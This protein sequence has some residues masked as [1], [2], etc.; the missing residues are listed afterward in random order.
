[1]WAHV[2][3]EFRCRRWNWA[4]QKHNIALKN[5]HSIRELRRRY[6]STR[7]IYM[8]DQI[9]DPDFVNGITGYQSQVLSDV[10]DSCAWRR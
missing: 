1:M 5:C 8:V 7:A 4:M 6:L 2:H 3:T 10:S 9:D